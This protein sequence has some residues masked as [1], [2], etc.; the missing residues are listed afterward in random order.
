MS[1]SMI[2]YA[3]PGEWHALAEA[4]ANE[5]R[6]QRGLPQTLQKRIRL[7]GRPVVAVSSPAF[8]PVLS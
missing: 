5:F 7:P 6:D 8:S 2:V 4:A 1:S 3:M